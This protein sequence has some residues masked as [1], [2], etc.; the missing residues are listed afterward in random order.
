MYTDPASKIRVFYMDDIGSAEISDDTSVNLARIKEDI[1][2]S[3]RDALYLSIESSSGALGCR[4]F[5]IL[6]ESEGL[7][8]CRWHVS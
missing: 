2:C 3:K 7:L 5:V 4:G 6:N 8:R 1:H